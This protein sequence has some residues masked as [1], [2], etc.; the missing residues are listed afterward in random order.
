MSQRLKSARAHLSEC[1][2]DVSMYQNALRVGSEAL[3]R[4]KAKMKDIQKAGNKIKSARID[5]KWDKESAKKGHKLAAPIENILKKRPLRI[6]KICARAMPGTTRKLEKCKGA[7]ARKYN[8]DQKIRLLRVIADKPEQVE[9]VMNAMALKKGERQRL[10]EQVRKA[11]TPEY[12]ARRAQVNA[13][14]RER[15]ATCSS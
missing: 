3:T 13:T 5:A 4:Q 12:L 8:L 1:A 6:C 15:R 2:P 11:T 7:A 9:A 10:E 14:R